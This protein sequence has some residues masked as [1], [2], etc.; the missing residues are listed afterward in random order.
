[1]IFNKTDQSIQVRLMFVLIPL[2]RSVQVVQQFK[3][4]FQL[5][6]ETYQL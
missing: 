6:V 2:S 1:M 4:V 3:K 5:K